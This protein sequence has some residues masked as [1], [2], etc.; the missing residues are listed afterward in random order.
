MDHFLFLGIDFGA[1]VPYSIPPRGTTLARP[2]TFQNQ[3]LKVDNRELLVF[4][5]ATNWTIF[6]G[7]NFSE[8]RGRKLKS[9]KG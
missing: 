6:E 9:F 1:V 8:L 3:S 5:K 7:E 4:E 2:S